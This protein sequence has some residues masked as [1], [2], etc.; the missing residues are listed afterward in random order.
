M[1]PQLHR[2]TLLRNSPTQIFKN[3]FSIIRVDKLKF[4]TSDSKSALDFASNDVYFHRQIFR[5]KKNSQ[6]CQMIIARDAKGIEGNHSEIRKIEKCYLRLEILW[7]PL[8]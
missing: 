2:L 5:A 7:H 4:L 1:V 3:G 6:G 8:I